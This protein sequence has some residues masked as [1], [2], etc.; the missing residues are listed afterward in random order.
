MKIRVLAPEDNKFADK[1][2]IY[3]QKTTKQTLSQKGLHQSNLAV[4]A[5]EKRADAG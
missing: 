3:R 1:R 4:K 5:G 2:E